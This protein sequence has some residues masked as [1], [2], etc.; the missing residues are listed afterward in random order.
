MT[1]NRV[2]L[3]C[4]VSKSEADRQSVYQSWI[5]RERGKKTHPGVLC[6]SRGQN[7]AGEQMTEKDKSYQKAAVT[8][9]KP[10][11]FSDLCAPQ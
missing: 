11:L 3:A 6:T 10:P 4:M 2:L 5:E 7:T 1:K 8:D 9:R